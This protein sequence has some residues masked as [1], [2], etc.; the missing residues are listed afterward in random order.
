M[1]MLKPTIINGVKNNIDTHRNLD[2]PNQLEI[3][4]TKTTVT[5]IEKH[6][7]EI[8]KCSYSPAAG[9]YSLEKS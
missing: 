1:H 5:I 2:K 9:L 7:K 4:G 3:T 8:I 6:N